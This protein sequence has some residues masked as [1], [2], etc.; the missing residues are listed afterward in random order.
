MQIRSPPPQQ[1][2]PDHK[3]PCISHG[4]ILILTPFVFAYLSAL[5][6]FHLSDSAST[7][8]HVNLVSDPQSKHIA[9]GVYH[10]TVQAA[11]GD[12]LITLLDRL[13]HFVPFLL[14]LLLWTNEQ[15]VEYDKHDNK[16]HERRDN[17]T[18]G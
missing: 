13:Q 2:K 12:D 9:L 6:A 17:T 4:P 1:T 7:D 15:E 5:L 10:F 8:S 18:G 16:R 3:G 11:D 14:L